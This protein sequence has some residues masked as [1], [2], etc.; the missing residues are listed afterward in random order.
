MTTLTSG[1]PTEGP[2]R[3]SGNPASTLS[4]AALVSARSPR[5]SGSSASTLS[6]GSLVSV[7]SPRASEYLASTWSSASSVS[8]QSPRASGSIGSSESSKTAES[9]EYEVVLGVCHLLNL[10]SISKL[11]Y[12]KVVLSVYLRVLLS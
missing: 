11:C 5:A 12:S 4:S 1:P 8:A 10:K 2:Q 9:Q 3:N 7:L 6:T